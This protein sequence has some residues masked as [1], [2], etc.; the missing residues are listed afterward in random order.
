MT[1][2]SF[3]W[4]IFL[5]AERGGGGRGGERE[6]WNILNQI[7][8]NCSFIWSIF[9]SAEGG[10]DGI[11]WIRLWRTVLQVRMDQYFQQFEKMTADL[12]REEELGITTR[13][14]VK[15]AQANQSSKKDSSKP[16]LCSRVKFNVLDI[17]DL[18]K[19]GWLL[20]RTALCVCMYACV[21]VCVC[22]CMRVCVCVCERERERERI[23]LRMNTLWQ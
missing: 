3:I 17:I 18:R 5:S 19:V 22:V 13:E 6:W 4:S 10:S 12:K 21:C 1:N 11:L 16:I 7:M 9:L 8:T 23:K 2:C 20:G 14:S 15:D